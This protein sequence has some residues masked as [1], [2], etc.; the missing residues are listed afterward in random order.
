M[1]PCHLIESS[2]LWG[3]FGGNTDVLRRGK[4]RR[5]AIH[6]KPDDYF[7]HLERRAHFFKGL[8]FRVGQQEKSDEY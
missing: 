1:V 2:I 5:A 4:K 8:S 3:N 6:L 7:S